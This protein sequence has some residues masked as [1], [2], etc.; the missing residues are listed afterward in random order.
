MVYLIIDHVRIDIYP[1][2]HCVIKNG[3]KYKPWASLDKIFQEWL[4]T[5]S[6]QFANEFVW[7]PSNSYALKHSN[8]I[9]TFPSG[10]STVGCL[11]WFLSLKYSLC[12]WALLISHLVSFCVKCRICHV[13]TGYL[14]VSG[15]CDPG[16]LCSSIW[17]TQ[18]HC[19]VHVDT[20]SRQGNGA[21]SA[22]IRTVTCGVTETVYLR[23]VH[24]IFQSLSD[25]LCHTLKHS[26]DICS[27]YQNCAYPFG[28]I[29]CPP[30]NAVC[31]PKSCATATS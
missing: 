28:S 21:R 5:P 15:R 4:S 30:T 22:A 29:T 6:L 14:D 3:I 2:N 31:R 20:L 26:Q 23:Q 9:N 25:W 16:S 11:L 24:T 8:G 18:K 17:C 10:M 13:F 12:S 1:Q 19:P 7:A 27:Q